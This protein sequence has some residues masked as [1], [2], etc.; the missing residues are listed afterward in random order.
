VR[1]TSITSSFK[2]LMHYLYES[3]HLYVSHIYSCIWYEILTHIWHINISYLSVTIFVSVVHHQEQLSLPHN[4][5]QG[6]DTTVGLFVR[7]YTDV[8]WKF[9]EIETTQVIMIPPQLHPKFLRFKYMIFVNW[10]FVHHNTS[11][12]KYDDIL[13]RAW[14]GCQ[15]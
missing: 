3:S 14:H 10:Q 2:V 12:I 4:V 7:A 8:D 1:F 15:Y 9:G 6:F 13:A 5:K 11:S